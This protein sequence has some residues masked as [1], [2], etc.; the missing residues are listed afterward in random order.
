MTNQRLMMECLSLF[1]TCCQCVY[2]IPPKLPPTD[3]RTIKSNRL[4]SSMNNFFPSTPRFA[5]LS[6]LLLQIILFPSVTYSFHD[7][8]TIGS[9]LNE[10]NNNIEKNNTICS[11]NLLKTSDSKQLLDDEG[12][13]SRAVQDDKC[14]VWFAR[15]TIPGAGLGMFAGRDFQHG[16]D[17]LAS[18]DV[19]IPIIDIKIHQLNTVDNFLWHEYTWDG[20]SL[21]MDHEGVSEVNGASPGF[22]SAVNCVLDLV[23]VDE[24]T[25]IHDEAG[26]TRQ[27]PGVGAFS[28]YHNRRTTAR[29]DIQ[30]GQELFA[31]Y[32]N[33]WFTTRVTQLGALPIRGDYEKAQTLLTRFTS[34]SIR[35][36]KPQ[37]MNDLWET[38]VWDSPFSYD[39]GVFTAFP[40]KWN[41]IYKAMRQG[42]SLYK[43]DQHSVTLKWLQQYGTCGDHLVVKTST[44]SQAGRG[45][46][47]R[48]TLAKGSIVAPLPLIHLPNRQSLDMYKIEGKTV[49][50]RKTVVGQQL[51]LN[52]CM[53]HNQSTILLCPYG[54]LTSLINH[55][56]TRANVKLQWSSP[57]R[58]NHRPSWFNL[59]VN[60]I[61][62]F[63]TSG[64]SMEL[65]ATRV[66]VEGEEILIDYGDEW[67]IAW[68][69]HVNTYPVTSSEYRSAAQLNAD[70]T[71][72]LK[73]EFDI[74]DGALP[75]PENI[76]IMCNYAF[77][78]P[79][80]EW[81]PQWQAGTILEFIEKVDEYFWPCEIINRKID[82]QSNTWYTVVV[83]DED[84]I[85]TVKFPNIPREGIR[86]FD[87]PYTSNIHW[88]SSFRHDMKVPEELFPVAWRNNVK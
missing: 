83:T 64:L 43:R 76:K 88:S 7:N 41:E 10:T 39:S 47:A 62:T 26:F 80:E 61:G 81:M 13:S 12:H 84:K 2:F 16:Q 56:Q 3:R 25:P 72:H 70:T 20:A 4:I 15:S 9:C 60:E 17:L 74:L 14:G 46:F 52:Y 1:F 33:G 31:N 45:A 78:K 63:L 54:A 82:G 65:L 23:N 48:H 68:Q 85:E 73:T 87:K 22:G 86:F 75:Y 66:I 6:G 11:D 51:L 55:N 34:L 32:G 27:D 8:K 38:F 29:G 42:L 21:V 67:E 50:N 36:A 40:K 49:K 30:A 71:V 79:V 24:V 59:S 58:S 19:V 35:Q 28:P 44:L 57:E 5:A 18:G 37:V 77:S 69:Y 53:G